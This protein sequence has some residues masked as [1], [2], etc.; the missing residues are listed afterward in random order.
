MN[1]QQKVKETLKEEL[2]V[3]KWICKTKYTKF[4]KLHKN[5]KNRGRNHLH[6]KF[7]QEN[8]KL[9]STTGENYQMN[10][11]MIKQKQGE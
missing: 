1:L 7:V 4:S 3:V 11:C 9:E 5:D 6:A 2:A 10:V 8:D